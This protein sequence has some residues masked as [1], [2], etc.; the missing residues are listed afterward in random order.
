MTDDNEK[1]DIATIQSQTVDV[2]PYGRINKGALF[3]REHVGTVKDDE[4]NE[5]DVALNMGGM[6]PMVESKQTGQYFSLSWQEI[7]KMAVEA[8]I[9]KEDMFDDG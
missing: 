5:Y 8:G 2:E 7:V 6:S 1:P 3:L 9:D 4:G